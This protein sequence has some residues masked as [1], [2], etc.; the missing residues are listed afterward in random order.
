MVCVYILY[1]GTNAFY[2]DLVIMSNCDKIVPLL[3][4]PWEELAE[5]I[6]LVF[7]FN[8]R[9]LKKISLQHEW[10]LKNS[11]NKLS[12]F[13]GDSPTLKNFKLN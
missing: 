6:V 5:F 7:I 9:S 11:G 10:S 12:Y 8:I 13:S 3:F 4:Y 2:S 1:H